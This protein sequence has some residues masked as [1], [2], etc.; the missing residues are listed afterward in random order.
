MTLRLCGCVLRAFV[1]TG[2]GNAPPQDRQGRGGARTPL[3][4]QSNSS[5]TAVPGIR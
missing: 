4:K 2:E 5:K 1:P 3:G